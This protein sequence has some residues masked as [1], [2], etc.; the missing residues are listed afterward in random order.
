[1]QFCDR[2]EKEITEATRIRFE[3]AQRMLDNQMTNVFMALD[4]IRSAN[5]NANDPVHLYMEC[6][7]LVSIRYTTLSVSYNA[8]RSGTLN[9]TV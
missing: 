3:M 8:R 4:L 6:R 5:Q 9:K 1:M 7:E 2:A